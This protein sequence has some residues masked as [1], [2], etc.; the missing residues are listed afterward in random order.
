MARNNPMQASSTPVSTIST[1]PQQVISTSPET[2]SAPN[3]QVVPFNTVNM[4]ELGQLIGGLQS[5]ANPFK[6]QF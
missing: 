4:E 5:N 3:Y 1:P 2:V 6:S